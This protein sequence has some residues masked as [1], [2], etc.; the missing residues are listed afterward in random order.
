M[1][2]RMLALHGPTAKVRKQ[3]MKQLKALTNSWSEDAEVMEGLLDGLTALTI[4]SQG[5][6]KKEAEAALKSLTLTD[7]PAKAC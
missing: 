3:S 4:Q 7:S 1:Q 2:L 6:E 5:A